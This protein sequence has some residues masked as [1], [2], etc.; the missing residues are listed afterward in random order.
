MTSTATIKHTL[1]IA[2]KCYFADIEA[3]PLHPKV[4][5]VLE[6]PYDYI[7]F[8]FYDDIFEI[9]YSP[10][11]EIR[12]QGTTNLSIK[13]R[14]IEIFKDKN[15]LLEPLYSHPKAFDRY[16]IRSSCTRYVLM[17]GKRLY[18]VDEPG[19]NRPVGLGL[20]GITAII[21]ASVIRPANLKV[22]FKKISK[23]TH[24]SFEATIDEWYAWASSHV[25]VAEISSIQ[26][27]DEIANINI[28][29]NEDFED[30]VVGLI[31]MLYETRKKTSIS[32]MEFL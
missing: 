19:T 2:K 15:S 12:H 31:V 11:A 29:F 13:K 10:V 21:E 14:E 18:D 24:K 30:Y 23:S 9:L 20:T 1:T 3:L 7:L 25:K 17:I 28:L 4:R 22:D 16:G 8:E 32:Y 26:Y 27:Q 6:I 5:Y